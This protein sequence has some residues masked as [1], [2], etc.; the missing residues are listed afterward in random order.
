MPLARGLMDRI[1]PEPAAVGDPWGLAAFERSRREWSAARPRWLRVPGGRALHAV[2]DGEQV[3]ICGVVP[4]RADG[5]VSP[6]RGPSFGQWKYRHRH[7]QC[8]RLAAR[9]WVQP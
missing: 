9:R 4:L 8:Q 6:W 3:P 5:T 7:Q 2:I 1:A